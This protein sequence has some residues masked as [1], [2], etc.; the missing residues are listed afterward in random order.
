MDNKYL[1]NIEGLNHENMDMR[2]KN[3]RI[4]KDAIDRGEMQRPDTGRD[5]NNH[6][7]TNYSFSPYSPAKAV[8]M[9]YTSGLKTAGIMDHDTISGARE[10]VEAG[11]IVGMATTIGMECRVDFSNTNLKGRTL[12]NPDQESIAYITIHGVP[13]TNIDLINDYFAP[14]RLRRNERNVKMVGRINEI[15]KPYDIAMDFERDVKSHSKC[16]EGG[17]ITER[18]ILYGLASKLIERFGKGREL[19]DFLKDRLKLNISPKVDGYLR[20]EANPH[21]VYDLLG[22]LK[23]DMVPM[24]YIKAG[25]ECPDAAETVKYCNEAGAVTAY[26]Y[27]GDITDSVTGD[28]KSRKF[29]DSYLDQ[30][31]DVLKEL[32]FRAVTYMPSRNTM[33][34]FRR[35][36]MLCEKYGFFQISGEDINTSRQSFVC[37]AARGDEFS[38]LYDS[39]WALIGHEK[40]ATEDVQKGM[41]SRETLSKYPNLNDR[42]KVYKEI[43]LR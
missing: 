40:A 30:L 17:T 22:A 43:G 19:A 23:S 39:T 32:G 7:H 3:L 8:W 21:Y 9:A 41:F 27:L 34:Q 13:H 25:E 14:Y 12:N 20:D 18:H 42:I 4:L 15:M 37:M 29:E 5:V 11:K 2:L 35:V 1:E 28:K 31:F 33:E 10:F 38:N 6:I 24:F 36:K 16:S 26:A